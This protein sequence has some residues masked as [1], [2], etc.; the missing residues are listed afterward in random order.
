MNEIGAIAGRM[1]GTVENCVSYADVYGTSY[2][3]G[4]IG[5]RDNAWATAL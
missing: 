1:Q 2:V 3:G 5:T 4:I